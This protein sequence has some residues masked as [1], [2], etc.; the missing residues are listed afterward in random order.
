MADQSTQ[1]IDI[2][3]DPAAVMAVIADFANY[4]VWAGSVKRAEVLDAGDGS[5]ARRVA[6]TLEAGPVRDE[7][8]LE[9]T[10]SGDRL[11]E[12]TLVSGQM[13]RAQHGRYDLVATA[14][15]THVT[16]FLSVDL[17]IPMLGLLKRKAERVVMD[18]AL[19][20]LKKRVEMIAA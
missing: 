15:G 8:E 20:E 19:K 17:T 5:R 7:Y 9:Y 18:T 14:T 13:M 1:S 10:W 2:D 6:F 3:A 12:W 4:P 11:V 16:Y